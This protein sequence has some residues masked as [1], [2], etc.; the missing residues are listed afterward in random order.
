MSKVKFGLSNVKVALRTESEGTVTY[1]TVVD[2]PGAV[3][4]SIE[5]ESDQN[6][7]YADNK[8]Y[9]TTN[10]KS[11]VS[12]ELE[13]AEIAKDIML[14]YLGYVKSKNGTVLETNTAVTPSF[15]L[16][17]QIETDEKAR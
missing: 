4:L 14:Q 2:I 1:G 15:A 12:L 11:S 10:S 3:N 13:I 7:F 9:F 16:M 5:R 17:F 6:I 8:A